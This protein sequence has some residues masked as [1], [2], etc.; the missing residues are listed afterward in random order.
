MASPDEDG[1]PLLPNPWDAILEA[2]RHQLPSL[3]SD[4]SSV[5][6]HLL[7]TSSEAPTVLS[8]HD[9]HDADRRA[10]CRVS[11]VPGCHLTALLILCQA[12]TGLSRWPRTGCPRSHLHQ[13]VL[14]SPFLNQPLK[15]VSVRPFGR[16]L[17]P[18]DSRR[19]WGR[20]GGWKLRPSWLCLWL[21]NP[22]PSHLST[23]RPRGRG[24]VHLPAK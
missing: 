6:K 24:A 15:S 16:E 7:P 22:N 1:Q 3:D 5:S 14:L 12:L 19:A 23:V 2:A 4:S 11:E 20:A 18:P 9:R 8:S 13:V 10:R 21:F 17:V